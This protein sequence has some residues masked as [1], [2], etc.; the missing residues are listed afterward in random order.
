MKAVDFL[1]YL[2]KFITV[3]LKDGN[4]DSG[5]IANHDDFINNPSDDMKVVLLNGLLHSEVSISKIIEINIANREDTAKIPL[6]G[7][8]DDELSPSEM[9]DK[10]N[11]LYEHSLLDDFDLDEL[12]NND[13]G[14]E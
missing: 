11:E 12:L 14:H 10:I 6:V 3:K 13:K 2:T 8:E 9:E 5:Y 4:I 7:Y 1:P